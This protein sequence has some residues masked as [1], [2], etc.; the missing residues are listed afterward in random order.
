MGKCP[1]RSGLEE[2]NCHQSLGRFIYTSP[3]DSGVLGTELWTR[4]QRHNVAKKFRE[5][6]YEAFA[7]GSGIEIRGVHLGSL[8][9]LAPVA[10]PSGWL[11]DGRMSLAHRAKWLDKYRDDETRAMDDVI[12]QGELAAA[13]WLESD[14]KG[15]QLLDLHDF[16]DHVET[17]ALSN[18]VESS[19]LA[20]D[21][22]LARFPTGSVDVLSVSQ[23]LF[24]LDIYIN[25]IRRTAHIA[26]QQ[27]LEAQRAGHRMTRTLSPVDI[28][29]V[30]SERNGAQAR[31]AFAVKRVDSSVLFSFGARLNLPPLAREGLY[32]PRGV[33]ISSIRSDTPVH[34]SRLGYGAEASRQYVV[35]A[36]QQI[37]A[38]FALLHDPLR[39][40]TGDRLDG[41]A[42]ES[43]RRTIHRIVELTFLIQTV[44]EPDVR[45]ELIVSL[46]DL[47]D[48][49]Q[50]PYLPSIRQ[51][52]RGRAWL[53]ESIA[54][55]ETERMRKL[56]ATLVDEI[57]TGVFTKHSDDTVSLPDG[58]TLG[59]E[60]YAERFLRAF[61]NS[62]THGFHTKKQAPAET[63]TFAVHTGEYPDSMAEFAIPMLEMFIG[64]AESWIRMFERRENKGT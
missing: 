37:Q 36:L 9:S 44:S 12:E 50:F 53:P 58:R 39:F 7:L 38:M 19:A 43:V 46:L 25:S 6:G 49:F 45:R 14:P 23:D 60:G 48:G 31:E 5:L 54:E 33:S 26:P 28:V 51:F 29:E 30:L 57:W 63:S 40:R 62:L 32:R 35:A 8:V 15:N 41:L 64:S 59:P 11:D 34:I 20:V 18:D 17:L 16:L 21:S 52:E 3:M 13:Q 10:G 4:E 61:R 27:M 42:W 22:F 56:R 55:P 47:Y 2:S 1:C 24:E